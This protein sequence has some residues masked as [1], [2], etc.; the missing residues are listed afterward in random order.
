M[1]KIFSG[2]IATVMV[3]LMCVSLT[4]CTNAK[5]VKGEKVTETEWKTAIGALFDEDAEFTIKLSTKSSVNYTHKTMVQ[6]TKWSATQTQELTGIKNGKLESVKG[7]SKLSV[8]GDKVAAEKALGKAKRTD[9]E[10]YSEVDDKSNAYIYEKGLDGEW[11]KEKVYNASVVFDEIDYI[12]KSLANSYSNFVYS[13]EH[14]GYVSKTYKKG[15]TNVTV[16]K[17][18]KAKLVAIYV[19]IETVQLTDAAQAYEKGFAKEEINMTI[20]YNAKKIKLPSV[21]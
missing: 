10:L 8:S 4:A 9:I 5:G 11:T 1:K 7:Y 16:Y 6:T 21:D 17:F 19:Y 14:N 13:K 12:A 2:I 15:D 3:A 18:K 20:T